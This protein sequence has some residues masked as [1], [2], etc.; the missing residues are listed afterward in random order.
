LKLSEEL[1][2][3][4][5]AIVGRKTKSFQPDF[6]LYGP[7]YSPR[8]LRFIQ[9]QNLVSIPRNPPVISVV[10]PS[11][12]QAVF[13]ERAIQS[14]VTQRYPRLEL[15]VVDGGSTDGSM[16]IIEKHSRHL[17]W[18]CSEPDDGQTQALNKGFTHTTGDIMAWLN[19]D[20]C[21]AP[22]V[23]A[24][25]AE[26]FA[27]H[28]DVDAVYG[29]RILIDENDRDI[30]RCILP[31][32]DDRV[33]SWAD[34]IPQETLFWRRCLWKNVGGKLDE[35]FGFAMDWELL[36]RFR[37]SGAKIIRLPYF[38][39]LF[40]IHSEQKT[41]AKIQEIGLAEMQMLRERYLGIVPPQYR[42]ALGVI[43]YLLK[44]RFVEYLWKTGMVRYD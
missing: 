28:S 10:I 2:N 11:F 30:G 42:V 33:L 38:M 13:L 32:H 14:L 22:G 27:G 43:W 20:D 9:S 18:W 40:R 16:E 8:P 15:V 6:V 12:N 35:G 7:Q 23:L 25:V 21:L 36:L 44:A 34:F 19:S 26:Y 3:R 1:L 24:R 31:L 39:G 5:L 17:A 41:S 4:L 37:A 29:H